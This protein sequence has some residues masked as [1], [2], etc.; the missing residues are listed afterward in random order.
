MSDSNYGTF[1]NV[2]RAA[3][4]RRKFPV[5]AKKVLKRFSA[6]KGT[7]SPEQNLRWLEQ[8]RLDFFTIARELNES[9]LK[10]AEEFDKELIRRSQK[11]LAG[12]DYV[13][14]GGA[15]CIL[16]Y[17][18]T[19]LVRPRIVV[20]TG[21]AAGFSSQAFLKALQ[22]NGQGLLYSSD[23]PYFRLP[24]PERFVGLLVEEDLKSR[25]KLFLDG[26]E[27]N[28]PKILHEVECIDIFHYDSDKS[29]SGRETTL[30]MIEPYLNH[31]GIT[32]MDD[33]L[34]NSFFHD[35]V[36][37]L[38][39]EKWKVLDVGGRYIGVIGPLA[40]SSGR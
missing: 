13:L 34:D 38:A 37:S 39:P 26:D 22:R 36:M 21:V 25:W 6:N 24:N 33:L 9:L 27:R 28:I 11:V 29:Y 20:E 1:L 5:M 32:I 31:A 16:L 23:F 14:G 10:E 4:N 19:R 7:L 12:I 8:N 30:R 35:Y 18:V 2:A 3:F 15:A 17:F 40:C